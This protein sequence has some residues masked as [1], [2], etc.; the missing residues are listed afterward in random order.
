MTLK[1]S[2]Q[3]V[4]ENK[5]LPLLD[6]DSLKGT[7]YYDFVNWRDGFKVFIL[8][9]DL[10][11]RI[12]F[13]KKIKERKSKRNKLKLE[14]KLPEEHLRNIESHYMAGNVALREIWFFFSSYR[15]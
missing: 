7:K 4:I 15:S 11:S 9:K 8:K 12:S 10:K 5:I 2:S 3:E 14:Y 13:I 6:S 1:L